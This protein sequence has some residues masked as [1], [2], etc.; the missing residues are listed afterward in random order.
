MIKVGM[1]AYLFENFSKTGY[2]G[3]IKTLPYPVLSAL[4]TK[5]YVAM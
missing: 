1:M 3:H 2:N 4:G 5:P